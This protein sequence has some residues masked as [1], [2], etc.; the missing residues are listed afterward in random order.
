MARTAAQLSPVT[1]SRVPHSAGREALLRAGSSSLEAQETNVGDGAFLFECPLQQPKIHFSDPCVRIST[2]AG[3][4]TRPVWAT[5]SHGYIETAITAATD[6]EANWFHAEHQER[7]KRVKASLART[8]QPANRQ[9]AFTHCG[10]GCFVQWSATKQTHRLSA[11]YCHDRFCERCARARARVISTNL[12]NEL[13][14]KSF[15]HL[16]LTLKH[17]AIPLSVE[18]TRII[19]CFRKLRE[20]KLWKQNVEGGVF[21]IEIK[22]GRDRLWHVHLHIVT[23][24]Q[25]IPQEALKNQW[26]AATGDSD[27]IWMHRYRDAQEVQSYVAKYAAKG[28]DAGIFE[29]GEKLDECVTAMKGRRLWSTFGA[30]RGLDLDAKGKDPGDWKFIGSLDRVVSAA[31]RGELWAVGIVKSLRKGYHD[32]QQRL[33]D[34]SGG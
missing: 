13:K 28:Y 17:R 20:T 22:I 33:P 6:L 30:W 15:V 9:E 12:A 2:V 1:A 14:G 25:Y 26:L 34:T 11:N 24:S 19:N 8:N 18:I 3:R 21:F 5:I 31:N 23:I 7:R 32:E 27:I 10:S 4:P 16:V 29:D